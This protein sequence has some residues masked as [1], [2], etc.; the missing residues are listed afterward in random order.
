[1]KIRRLRKLSACVFPLGIEK[2]KGMA[3][4]HFEAIHVLNV[5]IR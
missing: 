2:I 3:A 1:M 5:A 4:D